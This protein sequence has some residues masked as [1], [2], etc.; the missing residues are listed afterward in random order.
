MKTDEIIDSLKH[1]ALE[2]IKV[3]DFSIIPINPETKRPLVDT[4]GPYQINKPS[5][6]QVKSWWNKWST[7]GIGIITGSIS[8]LL[9][10]DI[11]K[12]KGWKYV[13]ETKRLGSEPPPIVRTGGGGR[14]IYYKY[15]ENHKITIGARIGKGKY[16]LDF[17]GKGGYVIA[18]P[19]KHP[20]GNRYCWDNSIEGY[21][22][23]KPP[24]WLLKELK[25]GN[26]SEE[27]VDDILD[28]V[29]EGRRNTSATKAAG[30]FLAKFDAENWD[31]AWESLRSWNQR[32]EP[33]LPKDELKRTFKSIAKR[34]KSKNSEGIRQPRGENKSDNW[35]R[36]NNLYREN[37]KKARFRAS[38][39]LLDEREFV[40]L[41]EGDQLLVYN[42]EDGTF[43]NYGR[44][45]IESRTQEKLKADLSSHDVSEI[46]GHVKRSSLV[47]E[48]NFGPENPNLICIEN[49]VFDIESEKLLDHDPKY[50][51]RQSIPVTYD[52]QAESEALTEFLNTTLRDDDIPLIEEIAG[53]C[54]YRDYF[55]QKA[56]MFVGSGSNGKGLTLDLITNMLGKDNISGKSLQQLTESGNRFAANSLYKKYANIAGDLPGGRLGDTGMFKQLTGQDLIEADV[57]YSKRPVKFQNYATMLF[58]ANKVP[59]SPD[60]TDAFHRRWI[61]I[62]FPYKFVSD[63]QEPNEKQ[64]DP[65]LRQ[66][67]DSE[68]VKSALFNRA[69]KGLQ[70]LLNKGKFSYDPS[71]SEARRNWERQARPIKAFAQDKI[72]TSEDKTEFK[73]K[74]YQAYKEYCKKND[75][76]E[77]EIKRQAQFSKELKKYADWDTTKKED[78]KTG[79]RKNA[80]AGLE[81]IEIPF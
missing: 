23:I 31:L 71:A 57:K 36:I 66:K 64:K 24:N 14:H 72:E 80:Y 79:K 47:K 6:K 2:Y 17:R 60:D 74:V 67:L 28:G 11:D 39:L 7:A 49:G 18:P 69:I 65:K 12:E 37:K 3:Y 8:N 70:R 35:S 81:L 26:N 42:D 38:E 21:K 56:F 52:P 5:T 55:I 29:E 75:V 63:P 78:P 61:L 43:S 22:P 73:S 19:S 15:P 41:P 58:S 77:N 10:L 46:I 33:P 44:E 59:Q 40:A 32:N 27:S 62:N 53:Y 25:A 76:A 13:T 4:W 50:Q 34:E 48:E 1:S 54:L 45:Y 51:F 20:S 9:V 16:G 30:R 68:K